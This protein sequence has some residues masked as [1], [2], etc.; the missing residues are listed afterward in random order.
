[1][2]AGEPLLTPAGL[3]RCYGSTP[4]GKSAL[5][6]CLAGIVVPDA[7]TITHRGGELSGPVRGHHADRHGGHGLPRPGG[8]PRTA[9]S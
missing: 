5:L 1:M 3:H 4:A 8:P 6:H 2:T 7:G 9:A